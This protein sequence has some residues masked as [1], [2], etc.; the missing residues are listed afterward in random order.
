MFPGRVHASPVVLY[1]SGPDPPAHRAA[2]AAGN[3]G[4]HQNLGE[5]PQLQR[6]R[7][8]EPGLNRVA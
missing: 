1:R 4:T 5:H 2:W 6:I 8:V 3:G 7:Y